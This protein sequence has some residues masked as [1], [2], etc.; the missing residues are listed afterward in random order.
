MRLLLLLQQRFAVHLRSSAGIVLSRLQ[1]LL[2]LLRLRTLVNASHLLPL[3][4][5]QPSVVPMLEDILVGQRIAA[6]FILILLML[7]Q[8]VLGVRELDLV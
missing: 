7:L 3:H 5:F 4:D 2:L 8:L 1:L 6:I